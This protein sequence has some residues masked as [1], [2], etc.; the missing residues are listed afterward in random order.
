[1]RSGLNGLSLKSNFQCVERVP[2][3]E[4]AQAAETSGKNV[5]ERIGSG[6]VMHFSSRTFRNSSFVGERKTIVDGM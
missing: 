3:H 6:S 1:M 4:G 2:D 5:P